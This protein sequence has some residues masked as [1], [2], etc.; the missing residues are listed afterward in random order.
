MSRQT[1]DARTAFASLNAATAAGP[2]TEVVFAPYGDGELPYGFTW[3]VVI[4]GSPTTATVVLEASLDGVNWATVDTNTG[5]AKPI[6]VR[7]LA[8]FKALMLRAN[9]TALTG[10]TSPTVSAYIT[11]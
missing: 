2:G 6:E 4:T 1:Y 5:A 9:L 3:Q 8:S 11:A 10:G 7:S